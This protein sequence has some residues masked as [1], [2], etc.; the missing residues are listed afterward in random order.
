MAVLI[1]VA[2][3]IG[4]ALA[5]AGSM[6]WEILWPL[7]LGFAL[8]RSN[9]DGQVASK[10]T[11]PGTETC[12][13]ATRVRPRSRVA[14]GANGRHHERAGIVSQTIRCP[15]FDALFRRKLFR[16]SPV[17]RGLLHG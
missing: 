8:T 1:T 2:E 17:K 10:A 12:R 9:S 7:V 6:G 16:T 11:T 15:H 4:R 3:A 5:A 14:S 13:E